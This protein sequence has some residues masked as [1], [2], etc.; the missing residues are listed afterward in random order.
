MSKFKRTTGLILL[1]AALQACAFLPGSQDIEGEASE[2]EP[3]TATET[4]VAPP[5]ETAPPTDTPEAPATPEPSA[6]CPAAGEGSVQYI[7]RENGFCLLYP[8]N[9]EP[10]EYF[11]HPEER[12]HLLGPVLDPNAMETIRV[13]LTI[14]YNGPAEDLDSFQYA[15]QWL[16]F[17]SVHY[18]PER[19]TGFIGDQPAVIY[20]GLPAYNA[21]EQSAFIVAN[22]IKYRIVLAPQI[23]SVPELDEHVRRVW[24]TVTDTLVFFPPENERTYTRPQ[25]VCPQ[26]DAEHKQYIHY[27]DG[28]CLLY[29]DEYA[30]YYTSANEVSIVVGSLMNHI[31]P[32]ASISVERAAGRT[33]TQA[34]D[35]L[36][37]EFGGGAGFDIERDSTTV[38]GQE[39]IVLDNM[40]GQ[41]LHRRVVVL[42]G[43]LLYWLFFTPAG[44]EYGEVATG[45]EALYETIIDSLIFL[46]GPVAS[47]PGD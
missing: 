25:D 32:R 5:S 43:D 29:P 16:D 11:Q 17:F 3:A 12:L 47:L 6:L 40:P 18:D 13:T 15:L 31:E 9:F 42:Y 8:D 26:P 7:S 22:G 37:A 41:D 1:F 27:A 35:E 33:A 45:T 36:M 20:T 38:G 30:V 46:S 23:G 24:Q 39:A 44:A 4:I 21:A 10:H 14:E 34:A 19:E 2:P 28:Y